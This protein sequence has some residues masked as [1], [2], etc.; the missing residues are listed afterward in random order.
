ME[1][2]FWHERW[3]RNEI[4]F[5]QFQVNPILSEYWKLVCPFQSGG[6][7]FVPLCG[8]SLDMVWL[9]R[10]GHYIL[11]VELSPLAI[12]D[13]FTEQGIPVNSR[14]FEGF[15]SHEGDGIRLLCG[16]FFDLQPE[17]LE[18]IQAVYDRAALIALP[19]EMQSRYA[20]QLLHLLPQR[21]PI[22]LITFEYD[23]AE[24]EGPPFSTSE[25]KVRSLFGQSYQIETLCANEI[26]EDNPGL[27]NRG[28]T[29]LT[30]KAYYLHA[31]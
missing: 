25:E 17:H 13:F 14:Q 30:E 22:L 11:G 28:L 31:D 4:G 3:K 19:Q 15:Q 12:K 24:M 27:K 29:R 8:K 1:P 5:H 21:P 18:N 2:Q 9:R 7:V 26:L 23:Q 16:D 20:E 10:Q 6:Q